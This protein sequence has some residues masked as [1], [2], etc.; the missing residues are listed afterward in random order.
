MTPCVSLAL[1]LKNVWKF[2]GG[3]SEPG[4]DIGMYLYISDKLENVWK[5]HV[6]FWFSS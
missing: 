1:Q 5:F 3:L 4:E 6:S 2:P